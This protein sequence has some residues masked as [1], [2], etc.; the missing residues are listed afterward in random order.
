MPVT[1]DDSLFRRH[2]A[3]RLARIRDMR[4]AM[5]IVEQDIITSTD[6][7]FRRAQTPEGTAWE[8][9]KKSTIKQRRK[10]SS[11]P[12]NDTGVLRASITTGKK[13]N[14]NQV[15]NQS[16]QVGT[17]LP[18][19]AIH[20]FG[21]TINRDARSGMIS[22]KM[23]DGK[24]QFHGGLKSMK[25]GFAESTKYTKKGTYM[26]LRHSF[27][28]YTITI[29]CRQYMGLTPK[30]REKYNRICTKYILT[31]ELR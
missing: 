19:A 2:E 9:L 24:M 21:G 3:E 1:I 12:L 11:K 26:R 28:A 17:N 18:Y 4:P 10:G 30:M 31:G 7:N 20:Q 22:W 23:K 15:N 14:V 25:N 6:M 8:P 16:V 27:K 13:G 29:P 5:Q